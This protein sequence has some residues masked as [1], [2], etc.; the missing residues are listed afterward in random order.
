MSLALAT[1]SWVCLS[2][3]SLAALRASSMI[4]EASIWAF[5]AL[6]AH[7]LLGSLELGLHVIG[8]LQSRG[9]LP[10]ARRVSQ[11]PA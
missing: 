5:F 1:L 6:A 7:L 2:R 11:G 3:N 9:D 8:I 10:G 4:R